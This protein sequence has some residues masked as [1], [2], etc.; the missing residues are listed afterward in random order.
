MKN[1]RNPYIHL[2]NGVSIWPFSI[3]LNNKKSKNRA[4]F[5]ITMSNMRRR[6]RKK[7]KWKINVRNERTYPFSLLSVQFFFIFFVRFWFAITVCFYCEI[8]SCHYSY[9][10]R[11]NRVFAKIE[12]KEAK[13]NHGRGLKCCKNGSRSIYTYFSINLHHGPIDRLDKLPEKSASNEWVNRSKR[14]TEC[15]SE[16]SNQRMLISWQHRSTLGADSFS[17][18][19]IKWVWPFADV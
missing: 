7:K 12:L 3:R 18:N 1:A 2:L 8:L 14:L 9:G 15:S 13:K 10:P 6:E 16:I 11:Y 5:Y 17:M 19:K 4:S